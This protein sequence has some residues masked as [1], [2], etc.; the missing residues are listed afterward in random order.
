MSIIIFTQIREAEDDAGLRTVCLTEA[1]IF[2]NS[3]YSKPITAVKLSD[4]DNL[5]KTI[6]LHHCL[7]RMKADIDQF[8][9]GL[10]TLGVGD[11]IKAHPQLFEPLFAHNK[12][13]PLTAG[14]Q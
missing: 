9:L 13:A 6:K 12:T 8:Q 4:R 14:A 10:A 3:G 2:L 5:L 11:A 1:D 7:L